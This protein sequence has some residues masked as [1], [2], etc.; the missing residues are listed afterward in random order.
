MI[1]ISLLSGNPVLFCVE[2]QIKMTIPSRWTPEQ[3]ILKVLT[4]VT[5]TKK[6][7]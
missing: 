5:Y 4:K 2:F 3:Y 6:N 7:I 1:L